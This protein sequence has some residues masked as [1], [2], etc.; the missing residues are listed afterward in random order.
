MQT[1][2]RG[3]IG[4]LL[5]VIVAAFGV[6]I[7]HKGLGHAQGSKQV[8]DARLSPPNWQ[9]L[10]LDE[11]EW[12]QKLPL[13]ALVHQSRSIII[14]VALRNIC[15]QL[16]DGTYVTEYG[17]L[18][19]EVIKGSS[20][21]DDIIIVRMPGGRFTL[22][23][24]TILEARTRSVRKMQNDKRYIMFLKPAAGSPG[25]AFN[26]LNGSQGLYEIPSN[27]SRVVHLGRPLGL[28]LADDGEE[29]APFIDQIRSF[30]RIR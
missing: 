14:G 2:K 19:E 17:V 1:I 13:T 11:P 6:L 18:V 3:H 29:I 12:G 9:T 20:R 21:P 15:R 30:V 10:D 23:D 28:P 26:S 5:I 24:G 16:H 22:A 4:L 25:N 27:G 7:G 8:I